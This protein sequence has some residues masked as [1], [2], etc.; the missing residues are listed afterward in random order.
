[1][2]E[3]TKL[4]VY[5]VL[6]AT[7]AKSKNPSELYR[8]SLSNGCGDAGEQAEIKQLKTVSLWWVN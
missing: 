8:K 2:R 5:Q 7:L 1:M 3:L 4:E 6:P